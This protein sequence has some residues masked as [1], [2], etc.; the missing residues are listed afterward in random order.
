MGRLQSGR[1]ASRAE[2]MAH[3]LRERRDNEPFFAPD[4]AIPTMRG[5]RRIA[6]PLHSAVRVRQA[7][8]RALIAAGQRLDSE[9][10]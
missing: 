4:E 1:A 3:Y 5:S 2:I 9:A 6:T 8:G 7:I 10:A